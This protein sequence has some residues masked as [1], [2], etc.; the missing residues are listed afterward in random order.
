MRA[1]LLPRDANSHCTS[2]R[3]CARDDAMTAPPLAALQQAVLNVWKL[4]FEIRQFWKDHSE[5]T[6]DR[7]LHIHF[8]V[9][10]SESGPLQQHTP[11]VYV[12]LGFVSGDEGMELA[13]RMT[14]MIAEYS[15]M[16]T[17]FRMLKIKF[18][19]LIMQNYLTDQESSA[20]ERWP[21][22]NEDLPRL[23]LDFTGAEMNERLMHQVL[24]L[25]TMPRIFNPADPAEMLAST[26]RRS[27]MRTVAIGLHVERCNLNGQSLL[28]MQGLLDRVFEHPGRQYAVNLLHLSGSEMSAAYCASVAGILKKNQVYGIE[29][30][31]LGNF[32]RETRL[33]NE[34]RHS[35]QSLV[36]AAVNESTISSESPPA[37]R[38]ALQRLSLSGNAP[39]VDQFAAVCSALRYGCTVTNLS[40]SYLCRGMER[41]D[42]EQCWRWLAFGLFCRR[43]KRFARTFRLEKIS[44]EGTFLDEA[45]VRAF[46][47][48]LQNPEAE[49]VYQGKSMGVA[50]EERDSIM[51]CT[52]AEGSK[53]YSAAEAT[54]TC[55]SLVSEER[56]FEALCEENGRLCLVI[57]GFG[58]GWVEAEQ[59]TSTEREV[60]DVA[61]KQNGARYQLTM[62]ELYENE[63]SQSA[64][65]V[66]IETIGHRLT[67]LETRYIY[68]ERGTLVAAICTHCVNLERLDLESCD[69]IGD[70]IQSLMKAL[71]GDLGNRL[72]SLNLNGNDIRD[73][74]FEQLIEV[75][76]D[77]ERI[78]VLQELRLAEIPMGQRAVARLLGSLRINKT[79]RVLEVDDS[80]DVDRNQLESEHQNKLLGGDPLPL[81][82]KLAFLS[83][84][85]LHPTLATRCRSMDRLV[86]SLIFEFAAVQVRRQIFWRV[87]SYHH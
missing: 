42:K 22:Q 65:R 85:D 3:D 27:L 28:L 52:V 47:G 8:H 63:I 11:A 43:S 61:G 86:V 77:A 73:G 36:V 30:L 25:M 23:A 83:I 80:Y 35:L 50:A 67:S 69:L 68:S 16:L 6:G 60:F 66:L 87:P 76:S 7:F 49:L 71:R 55:A 75:L 51:I 56:E 78:P 79:L 31:R 57:P 72:V 18:W 64:F 81:D 59:V 39:G 54:S 44:L 45:A 17:P 29:E 5:R 19:K 46:R 2:T 40:L 53:I 20:I 74:V 70:E 12:R 58:L 82:R 14:A 38:A 37:L 26:K 62:N 41:R 4:L 32:T 84:L 15:R 24:N 34:M 33:S 48:T 1:L 9:N 10:D 21:V 13:L